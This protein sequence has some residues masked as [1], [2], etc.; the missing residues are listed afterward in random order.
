MGH[1]YFKLGKTNWGV[2]LRRNHQQA[3]ND[4]IIISKRLISGDRFGWAGVGGLNGFKTCV[5]QVIKIELDRKKAQ[6]MEWKK[7]Y[8]KK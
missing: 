3:L 6:A 4:S 7:T 2:F 1:F 8:Q 5:P